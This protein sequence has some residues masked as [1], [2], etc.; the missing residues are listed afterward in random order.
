[1]EIGEHCDPKPPKGAGSLEESNAPALDALA[2]IR[3][4][5]AIIPKSSWRRGE[6]DTAITNMKL[7]QQRLV[8]RHGGEVPP[9]MVRVVAEDG[10]R[11]L[12]VV[13]HGREHGVGLGDLV[14]H[15]EHIGRSLVV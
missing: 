14:H 1:M 3:T 6:T 12:L 7:E 13:V 5:E 8:A 11:Q 4:M 9:Q 10:R 15:P 2:H